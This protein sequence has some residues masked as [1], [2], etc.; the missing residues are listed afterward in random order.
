M[1]PLR[2]ISLY[3]LCCHT[4]TGLAEE[5]SRSVVNELPARSNP[6]V[7]VPASRIVYFEAIE[8]YT[9]SCTCHPSIVM[10]PSSLTPQVLV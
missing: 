1:F 9:P 7:A 3:L 8:G 5:D 4:H 6:A 10:M 2:F